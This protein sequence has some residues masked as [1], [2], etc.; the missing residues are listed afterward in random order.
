MPSEE[1]EEMIDVAGAARL[2]GVCK[3]VILS[4]YIRQGMLPYPD[5]A[6]R[7]PL[8]TIKALAASFDAE[9]KTRGK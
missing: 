3:R 9:R 6:G 4:E 1:I 5:A 2:L 7:W 8:S